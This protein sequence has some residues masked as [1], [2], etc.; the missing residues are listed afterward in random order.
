MLEE[1]AMNN[2]YAR[3][4]AHSYHSCIEIDFNA[5]IHVK[6]WQSHWSVKRWS[7]TPGHSACL[8]DMLRTIIMQGL[9]LAAIIVV[10]KKT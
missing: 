2:N 4:N 3:F 9:T 8:K 5:T 6:L 10:Q 7:R 1:Y